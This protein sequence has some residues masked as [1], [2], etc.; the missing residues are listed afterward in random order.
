[1]ATKRVKY[2][3]YIEETKKQHKI[4]KRVARASASK[5][6]GKTKDQD[7]SLVYKEGD[8][9]VRY[10]NGTKTTIRVLKHK[11]RTVKKG[12]SV[13]LSKR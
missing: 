13:K 4:L 6:V 5:A 10:K 1:M 11:S 3:T 9:I 8:K 7:V 12:T 2:L